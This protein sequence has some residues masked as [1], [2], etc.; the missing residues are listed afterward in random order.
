MGEK[1]RP[2]TQSYLLPYLH[3]RPIGNGVGEMYEFEQKD[4]LKY[5]TVWRV[6]ASGEIVSCTDRS[7]GE[8]CDAQASPARDA[9]AGSRPGIGSL[10]WWQR[11]EQE[12]LQVG[13]GLLR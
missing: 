7:H 12:P 13:H 2:H 11:Q 9:F 4:Y 10:Q 1:Q 8:T 5:A 6:S 3:I